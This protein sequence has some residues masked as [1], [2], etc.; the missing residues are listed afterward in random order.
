M[1]YEYICTYKYHTSIYTQ[2]TYIQAKNVESGKE[3]VICRRNENEN[4]I[5]TYM[6]IKNLTLYIHT[7]K[8]YY[9]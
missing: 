9:C 8:L 7:Y 3:L 1:Q 2:D 4:E 6:C 5:F